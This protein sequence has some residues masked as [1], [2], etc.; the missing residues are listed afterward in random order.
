VQSWNESHFD[1]LSWHDNHVHGF[2]IRAGQH[3]AGELI[4]D[5]DFIVEWLRPGDGALRF[6]VAPATLTFHDVYDLV[7]NLDY[8]SVQA[9]IEPFSIK[10]IEREPYV[11]PGGA[12]GFRWRIPVNWPAGSITFVGRR[13]T[14]VLRSEP[15]ETETQHL[16]ASQRVPISGAM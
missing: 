3:G 1:E 5:L 13:F 10:D 8:P 11:F 7:V 14:Q 12:S 9:G 15:V 4:L 16:P 6:R 2:W